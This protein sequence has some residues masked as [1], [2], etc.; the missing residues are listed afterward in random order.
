MF[1][2]VAL[3]ALAAVALGAATLGTS[4]TT[5]APAS[6]QW[7]RPHYGYRHGPPPPHYWGGRPRYRHHYYGRPH[8]GPPRP[9]WARPHYYRRH[10]HGW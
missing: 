2:N 4:I 10:H 1:R 9:Y 7:D 5:A 8:W 3:G 6:A